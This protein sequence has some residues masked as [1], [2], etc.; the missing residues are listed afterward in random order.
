MAGHS[1]VN[2][3]FT[4]QTVAFFALRARVRGL[5]LDVANE[6]AASC[7]AKYKLSGSGVNEMV[8]CRFEDLGPLTLL[9][10]AS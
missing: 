4:V 2:Q 5:V 1:N 3:I 7:H 9:Q 8:Y 6:S 10:K